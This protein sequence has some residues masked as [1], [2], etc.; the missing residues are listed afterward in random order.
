M[1]NLDRANQRQPDL[2][3]GF[4]F[5]SFRRSGEPEIAPQ[6]WST[7]LQHQTELQKRTSQ[8]HQIEAEDRRKRRL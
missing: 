2:S 6:S 1:L 3:G 7:E 8:D 5:N 4:A